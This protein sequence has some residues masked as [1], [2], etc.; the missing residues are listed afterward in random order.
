ME[1]TKAYLNKSIPIIDSLWDRDDL[2]SVAISQEPD[3]ILGNNI[4]VLKA[5]R[6][7]ISLSWFI[8]SVYDYNMANESISYAQVFN[9]VRRGLSNLGFD[10]NDS[11]YMDVTLEISRLCF[12]YICNTSGRNRSRV[13]KSIKLDLLENCNNDPRCWICGHKFCNEAINKFLGKPHNIQLPNSVDM[14]FPS[15][16]TE[17]DY[18]IEVEHKKPFSSGG[19]DVDDLSNIALSCGFCN[20]HKWKFISLYDVNRSLRGY[21]HP[22]LGVVSIPQPYWS[23]RLLALSERC[24]EPGCTAKKSSTRLYIDKVNPIGSMTPTNMKVVC[25]RHRSNSGDRVVPSSDYK[26]RLKYTRSSII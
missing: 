12:S 23:I 6:S 15:G 11:S 19:A 25:K 18:V 14:Y 9:H 22:R 10:N 17:R 5:D 13:T 7:I 26:S 20:R 1:L 2:C 24:S 8:E 16:L 4:A 3:N 21:V